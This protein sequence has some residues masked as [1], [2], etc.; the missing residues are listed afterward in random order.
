MRPPL[1]KEIWYNDDRVLMKN[2]KFKQWNGSERSLFYEPA[3]FY[4][5]CKE[6]PN[7]ANGGVAVARGWEVTKLNPIQRVIT[8]DDGKEITYD[9]CLIATGA[10]PK[11]L[12][13]FEKASPELKEKI[14]LFRTIY[15]F[16]DLEEICNEAETVVV[17]GGGFLGSEI[18]CALARYGKFFGSNTT[19]KKTEI[20]RSNS[21]YLK[22]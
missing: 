16:E 18:S 2:L 17:V 13:I 15:D 21:R 19:Y 4:V 11:N 10:S 12:D 5:D 6:L 14:T 8:L 3:D 22:N 9:K 1:S 20:L 7:V